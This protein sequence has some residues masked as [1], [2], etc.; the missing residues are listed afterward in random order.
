MTD[1]SQLT[2]RPAHRSGVRC[3]LFAS[4]V[5][6]FFASIH[7]VSISAPGYCHLSAAGLVPDVFFSNSKRALKFPKQQVA[8]DDDNVD[9]IIHQ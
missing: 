7:V 9:N 8:Y 1:V 4:S 5:R 3:L 6:L 2:S